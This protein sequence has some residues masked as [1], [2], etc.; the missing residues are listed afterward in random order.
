MKKIWIT[1]E[2][3]RERE[4]ERKREREKRSPCVFY[5]ESGW[6]M[7]GAIRYERYRSNV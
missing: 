3:E 7:I 4:R 5:Y 6:L 1:R 2:R